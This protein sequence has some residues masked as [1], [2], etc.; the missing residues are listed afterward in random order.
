MVFVLVPDEAAAEVMREHVNPALRPGAMVGFACGFA[1]RF[2]GVPLRDDVDVVMVSPKGPG[3]T[4]R[5][6]FVEGGG[7]PAFLAVHQDATGR[8]LELALAFAAGIGSGRLAVIE[9][10][11]AE[12]AETDLFGEQAVLCGGIP[13]LME[14][15]FKTLVAAGYSPAAAYIECIWEAKAILDLIF[16]R[17]IDGMYENI[18]P[19]ARYGGLTRGP[20]IIDEHAKQKMA[21]VLREI[22]SGSFAAE[23]MA[24]REMP[25]PE[26]D[27]TV[28]ETWRRLS[29]AF[30][31]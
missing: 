26:I 12:E 2:A 31:R 22:R 1:V 25:K 27:E 21:E 13:K 16:E 10:T 28:K 7:L 18:S 23:M 24:L 4:L 3:R 6:R 20:M 15:G 11:M 9:S 19:T 5:E 14:E 8:A 30:G 17:G 29:E